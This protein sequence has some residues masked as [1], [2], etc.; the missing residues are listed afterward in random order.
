MSGKTVITKRKRLALVCSGGAVKAA[1]FHMGVCLA[2]KE[3]GFFFRGGLK[4][5]DPSPLRAREFDVYVGSS[6]GSFVATYLAAGYTVDQIFDAYMGRNK[7]SA[8]LRPITYS[9]L[10]SLKGSPHESEDEKKLAQKISSITGAAIN[11]L[12]KRQKLLTMAGVFSTSG[13]E[14]YMREEVLPSNNFKDYAADLYIAGTQLNH[15]KR[16]IF[17]KYLLPSPPDDP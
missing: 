9:T 3:K 8:P 14:S 16:V 6:A 10:M 13:I 12:Y 2:L 4:T 7:E 11:L 17:N 15:S 5:K 1:A